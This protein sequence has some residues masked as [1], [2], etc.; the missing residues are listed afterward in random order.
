MNIKTRIRTRLIA[1]AS[2]FITNVNQ[3]TYVA[4]GEVM[5]SVLVDC[6][7]TFPELTFHNRGEFFTHSMSYINGWY[8]Q[9]RTFDSIAFVAYSDPRRKLAEHL[10]MMLHYADSWDKSQT[11]PRD[12]AWWEEC[13]RGCAADARNE[14]NF[15]NNNKTQEV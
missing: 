11:L 9:G 5:G 15:L 14:H 1:V 13:I 10:S 7:D 12:L 2:D 6:A 3:P 4:L 8:R